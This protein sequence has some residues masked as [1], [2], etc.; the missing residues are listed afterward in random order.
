M[1][2]TSSASLARA[3]IWARMSSIFTLYYICTSLFSIRE[4]VNI[5]IELIRVMGCYIAIT[6]DSGTEGTLYK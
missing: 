5:I 2:P 3:L 1:R 6:S 4:W